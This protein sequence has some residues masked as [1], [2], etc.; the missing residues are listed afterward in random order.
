MSVIALV[1]G[2]L[3]KA[4]ASK[5]AKTGAPYAVATML[6]ATDDGDLFVNVI[7]FGQAG[8]TLAALGVGDSLS[9]TG[10]VKLTHWTG[11]DG[12]ERHGLSVIADGV[13]TPYQVSLRKRRSAPELQRCPE[14]QADVDTAGRE[15]DHGND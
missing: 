3:V 13:L 5:I 11:N 14:F 4:P 1:A 9:V 8:Q 2:K 15:Q 12:Q 10:R 6:A 7:A